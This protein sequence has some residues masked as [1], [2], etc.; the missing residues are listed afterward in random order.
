M[1]R[2]ATTNYGADPTTQFAWATTDNDLFD[3]EQDLYRLA[4][5]LEL[6][7]HGAGRG[8]PVSRLA[9]NAVVS[10]SISALSVQT[11]HLANL[12]VTNAKIGPNAVS[13]DKLT[14]PLVQTVNS[15]A[16]SILMQNT[17][18]TFRFGV[19]VATNGLVS[20]G[21]GTNA[22][23]GTNLIL[24]QTG[25][26]SVGTGE[27]SGLFNILQVGTAFNSGMRIYNPNTTFF[28]DFYQDGNG[29]FQILA[30]NST[31]PLTIQATTGK[32]SVGSGTD[33]TARLSIVQSAGTNADGFYTRF[34][35]G[36]GRGFVDGSGHYHLESNN[37]TVMLWHG[38]P[39]FTP[40]A[41]LGVHLG[42][43]SWRWSEIH[44]NVIVAS[45]SISG[46]GSVPVNG[47]IIFRT[48]AELAAAGAIWSA[49]TSLAGR[50]PVGAGTTFGQTF[51]EG[52]AYGANWTPASALTLTNA[53]PSET[54]PVGA[55]GTQV[56]SAGHVH[57]NT[58]NNTGSVWHP[59]MFGV[60]FGRRIS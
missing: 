46:P 15:Y 8:L 58:L 12:N 52:G 28:T 57:N 34:G 30:S 23:M 35:G 60:V 24:G 16:G 31:Q 17:E 38:A 39:Y 55:G 11:T 48:A 53:G 3:R 13:F 25:K 21:A 22:I 10:A 49:E 51:A 42:H 41:D 7:D 50:M 2:V 47:I 56:A 26:V 54:F 18:G 45:T 20:L 37:T 36:L 33:F 40:T 9:A 1:S 27:G 43:P 5:A 19:Y 14:V 4:Q 44:G 32:V 29:H 59:P 6:H